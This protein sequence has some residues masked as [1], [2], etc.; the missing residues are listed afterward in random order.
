MILNHDYVNFAKLIRYK[1]QFFKVDV[2]L[3]GT[4]S[5]V[6]EADRQVQ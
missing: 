6:S 1:T 4:Y 3:I 5:T 2:S